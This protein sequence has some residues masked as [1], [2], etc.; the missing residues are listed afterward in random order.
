MPPVVAPRVTWVSGESR[1]ALFIELVMFYMVVA[2]W[3]VGHVIYN[4]RL[5]N[6]N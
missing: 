1:V 3:G 4:K 6:P 5:G 2:N